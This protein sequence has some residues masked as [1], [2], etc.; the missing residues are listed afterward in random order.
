MHVGVDVGGTKTHI[1]AATQDGQVID[2]VFPSSRWQRGELLSDEGNAARLAESLRAH[3]VGAGD[4]LVIGARGVDEPRQHALFSDRL[5]L[6]GLSGFRLVN[7]AE[8]LGPATG[9][10]PAIA[11]VIGTGSKVV[12]RDAAGRLVEVGGHGHILGDPGSGPALVRESVAALLAGRDGGAPDDALAAMLCAHFTARSIVEVAEIL[13]NDT[14][15]TFWAAAA[16]EVFRAAAQGSAVAESV[17]S[18]AIDQLAAAVVLASARGALGRHVVC[19]GGVVAHQPGFFAAFRSR[20]SGLRSGL[21]VHLLDQPPAL[22]ALALAR[23]MAP[24]A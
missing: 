14:G 3:G 13:T 12:G 11:V 23:R 1:I 4:A 21:E 2:T 7:D 5:R 22:G 16:P 15:L 18:T 10:E 6:A 24:A 19:A 9:F 8:L 17:I 20:L